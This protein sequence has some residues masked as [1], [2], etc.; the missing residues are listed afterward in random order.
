[1]LN[2]K[3]SKPSVQTQE[4]Y[5]QKMREALEAKNGKEAVG[6]LYSQICLDG[7]EK[8]MPV[9]CEKFREYAEN[10]SAVLNYITGCLLTVDIGIEPDYPAAM[11]YLDKAAKEGC[12]EAYCEM[13]CLIEEGKAG[14]ANRVKAMSY[15]S[16]ALDDSPKAMYRM[17]SLLE[18]GDGKDGAPEVALPFYR[19]A[20][21]RNY[22]PALKRMGDFCLEGKF[23]KRDEKKAFMYY[24]RGARAVF[25]MSLRKTGREGM[26]RSF[27]KN[28]RKLLRFHYEDHVDSICCLADCYCFGR[29]VERDIEKAIRFYLK[30]ARRGSGEAQFRV[31]VKYFAAGNHTKEG[32]GRQ[33]FLWCRRSAKTGFLYGKAALG[34]CY[35]NGYGTDRNPG[36]AAKWLKE[37]ADGG[38]DLSAFLLKWVLPKE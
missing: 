22:P 24:K 18:K 28:V 37:A 11:R 35:L 14:P 13:G 6:I 32:S 34:V 1:M 38:N 12:T 21:K 17:A 27:L 7:F 4:P 20:A 26:P 19:K 23:V 15:Y 36:L 25:D 2:P 31:A 33:G 5:Y 10:G 9:V 8:V 16:K 29:G 3:N 30:A